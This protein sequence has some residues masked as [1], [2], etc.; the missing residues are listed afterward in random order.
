MMEIRLS[1]PHPHNVLSLARETRHRSQRWGLGVL[2][3]VHVLRVA[4]PETGRSAGV[5]R[6][7]GARVRG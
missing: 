4:V 6:V 5:A 2:L 1:V 7:S 3:P